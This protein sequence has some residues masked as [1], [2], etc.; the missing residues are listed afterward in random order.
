MY[1]RWARG[2]TYGRRVE[3]LGELARQVFTCVITVKGAEGTDGMVAVPAGKRVESGDKLA[4]SSDSLGLSLEEVNELE[5]GVIIYDNEEILE[6]AVSGAP[7]GAGYVSVHEST[8]VRGLILGARVAQVSGVGLNAVPTRGWGSATHVLRYVCRILGQAPEALR[9]D[10]VS[11]VEQLG[12]LIRRQ[13][14][15][16]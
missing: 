8:G 11:T 13:V 12:G 1:V 3:E 2:L 6:V 7:K 14:S 10:V 5:P 16:E 4:N 15:E 9:A